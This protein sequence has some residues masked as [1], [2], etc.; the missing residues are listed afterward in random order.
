MVE[1]QAVNL[2]VAGSTPVP[3]PQAR[4][5]H[6]TVARGWR[7]FVWSAGGMEETIDAADCRGMTFGS[8]PVRRR[9]T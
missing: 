7:T 1:H 4:N 3:T 6:Q 9:P 2:A 8:S 5:L